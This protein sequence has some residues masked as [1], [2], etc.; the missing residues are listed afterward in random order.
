MV[1]I[2]RDKFQDVDE[3]FDKI[4]NLEMETIDLANKYSELLKEL[5]EIKNILMYVGIKSG[6]F[7][8]V[9]D[10]EEKTDEAKE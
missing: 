4:E 10:N 6:C 8:D 7:Q 2:I 3:M 9:L 1:D 5:T